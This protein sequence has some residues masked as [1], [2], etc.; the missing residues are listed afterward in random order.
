MPEKQIDGV[1]SGDPAGRTSLRAV[2]HLAAVA[3]ALL[4]PL[5]LFA[6]FWLR[7]E[8]VRSRHDLE[9]SL[10]A[11]ATALLQRVDAE[12]AQEIKVL[13]AIAAL[14]SLDEPNLE[15]FRRQAVEMASVM[16]QWAAVALI[17][18][19]SGRQLVNTSVPPPAELAATA[20]PEAV[21]RVATT[22]A[23][24]VLT[25]APELGGFYAEHA[26]LLF[27]P[28]VR[29]DAV[30]HVLVAGV[31]S[32]AVQDVVAEQSHDHRALALVADERDRI[33][34]RSRA[35]NRFVG[36]DVHEELRRAT[37]GLSSG[38]F[39]APTPD[40]ED[41]FTAFS[42]SPATGWLFVVATDHRQYDRLAERSTWATIA[43]VALSLTIAVILAVFVFYNVMERRLA[44]ERLAASR[45]LTDLDAR[46]LATTQEALAEQRKASSEREVLLREI[47]HRVKNNL[48]IVQSLLRLGSRD[49]APEQREA[50]ESAIRRIG[51]MARVHTLLYNSADLSSIEIGEYLGGLVREVAEAF[52]AKDRRIETVVDAEP[53]R[54]PLDTAVPLAFIAVEVLTNAFKH[55]FPLGRG[56][57][58]TV[59]AKR[60]GERGVLTIGDN[61][62]GLRPRQPKGR[63][64]LGLTIVSKLVQ[65]IEGT[66]EPPKE[67]E[68]TFR[69]EFPLG[70]PAAASAPPP[71]QDADAPRRAAGS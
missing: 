14:P 60:E 36:R 58:I 65:Q 43:A 30:R 46:L 42:R 67:G 37:A 17:E 57:T 47:Y 16:P 45:A 5:T 68:S 51:A 3:L 35:A 69:V 22:R 56:G 11:R 32:G 54:V 8:F 25:R 62:V 23:P 52:G 31:R 70:A 26:L 27:V 53:M 4:V 50:F 63:R 24:A 64:A 19:G 34:A 38:V 40:G 21:E 12:L 44:A 9:D 39:T 18:V 49:L 61:G 33:V 15:Q 20:I 2:Y 66:L 29:D 41:V 6:G 48:Q 71:P 7:Q 13:Q 55:A 28:V 1:G 10:R 59:S